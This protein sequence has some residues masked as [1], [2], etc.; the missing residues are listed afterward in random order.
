MV[1]TAKACSVVTTNR[2]MLVGRACW[3]LLGYPECRIGEV[4]L[5]VRPLGVAQSRL[6][7]AREGRTTLA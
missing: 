3:T 6:D 5:I 2:S 4:P 7:D 1:K